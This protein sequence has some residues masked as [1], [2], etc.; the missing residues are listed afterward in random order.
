MNYLIKV[1]IALF[2]S[3]YWIISQA[4][5][6]I[7]AAGGNAAGTGGTVSYSVGQVFYMTIDETSGSVIQGV[8]QPYEISVVTGIEEAKDITL[9]CSVYPNPASDYLTLRIENWDSENL[10]Y[11][12]LDPGGR[13]IG[14]KK[15][16]GYETQISLGALLPAVYFLKV[17]DGQKEIKTF[18]IIKN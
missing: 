11:K 9:L 18:K 17:L 13:I 10:S 12:L 2:L 5:S 4:Q 14:N 1:M 6:T 16:T 8:Q 15:I 7:P 3:G